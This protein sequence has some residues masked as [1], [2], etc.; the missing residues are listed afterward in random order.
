MRVVL[1]F[2]PIMLFALIFIGNGIYYRLNFC[3]FTFPVI[4]PTV[5]LLP[6]VVMAV[7]VGYICDK[8]S[9]FDSIIKGAGSKDTITVCIIFLLSG[10]FGKLTKSL[11]GADNCAYL[12]TTFLSQSTLLPGLFLLSAMFA[13]SLGSSLLTVAVMVPVALSVASG[14]DI[15]N[16]SIVS[17]VIGGAIFG[18]NLSLISDTTILAVQSQ[19]ASMK[20]KFIL[21]AKLALASLSV[22]MVVLLCVYD[23]SLISPTEHAHDALP[24]ETL[25]SMAPYI[26][27]VGM[28]LLGIPVPF[29]LSLGIGLSII[30]GTVLNEHYDTIFI[31]YNIYD[32]FLSVQDL[33]ILTMMS[34]GWVSFYM[35]LGPLTCL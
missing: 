28:A 22:L 2:L 4:P 12:L 7:V 9:Y 35:H 20:K 10:A 11:G 19:R 34:G 30:I 24:M 27:V 23:V 25:L 26:V 18:D 16:I 5:A 1:G 29:V 33:I 21:N 14:V 32:G 13:T 6:S 3:D 8:K 31:V 17:V 15:S